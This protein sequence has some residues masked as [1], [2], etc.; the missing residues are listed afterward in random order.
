MKK[1]I[2]ATTNPGKFQE[3]EKILGKFRI[4][5]EQKKLEIEEEKEQDVRDVAVDKAKKAF[6]KLKK[7]LIVEDTAFYLRAF[8][9]FPGTYAHEVIDRLKQKGVAKLVKGREKGAKFVSVVVFVSKNG[10]AK[11]FEGECE[12]SV[13]SPRG[14]A[15]RGVPYDAIFVPGGE[16]RTFAEMS[17]SEK[18]KF[19][20]RARAFEKFGKW[21]SKRK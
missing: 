15:R 6:K 11:I 10:R 17:K 12:G 7:E 16:K 14:K 3:A 21:F 5:V 19:S 18:E 20:H 9:G 1:I 2:F 4:K 8:P 13:V